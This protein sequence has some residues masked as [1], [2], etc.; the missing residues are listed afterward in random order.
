MVFAVA[1]AASAVA[2]AATSPFKTVKRDDFRQF[3]VGITFF[4][5]KLSPLLKNAEVR[6]RLFCTLYGRLPAGRRRRHRCLIRFSLAGCFIV[7][8]LL[9]ER[10]KKLLTLPSVPSFTLRTD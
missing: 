2:I 1:V 10:F 9:A 3:L 5:A 7:L 8:R 6:E 4:E